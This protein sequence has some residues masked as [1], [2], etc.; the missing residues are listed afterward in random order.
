MAGNYPG[1]GSGWAVEPGPDLHQLHRT[2]RRQ[3]RLLATLVKLAFAIILG[4]GVYRAA[5][6]LC[7]R[8]LLGGQSPEAQCPLPGSPCTSSTRR[9]SVIGMAWVVQAWASGIRYARGRSGP[10]PVFVFLYLAAISVGYVHAALMAGVTVG[11]LMVGEYVRSPQWRT[12][13]EARTGRRLAAKSLR[14]DHLL[15]GLLSSAVTWRTGEEKRTFNDN[16]PDGTVVGNIDG[17]YSVVRL[18]E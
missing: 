12:N 11:A 10:I 4:W 8:S 15:P 9:A 1:R 6:I 7:A 13:S 18:G 3:S 14:R 2:V 17:E 5:R 16:S